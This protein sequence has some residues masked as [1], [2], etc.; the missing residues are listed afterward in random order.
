MV[1]RTLATWP[2]RY[3]VS[4]EGKAPNTLRPGLVE[5]SCRYIKESSEIVEGLEATN[6]SSSSQRR[7]PELRP[8]KAT[9]KSD[10]LQETVFNH[11]KRVRASSLPVVMAPGIVHGLTWDSSCRSHENTN[12]RCSSFRLPEKLRTFSAEDLLHTALSSASVRATAML[13]SLRR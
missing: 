6:N 11:F 9:M 10:C 8:S 13:T 7:F 3:P 1:S 2:L 5:L 12:N 4:R